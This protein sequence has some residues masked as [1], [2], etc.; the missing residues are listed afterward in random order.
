MQLVGEFVYVRK[1]TFNASMNATLVP[2]LTS[3]SLPTQLLLVQ[4]LMRNQRCLP[5]TTRRL[6]AIGIN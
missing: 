3:F 6:G 2:L 4:L 1:V 5:K